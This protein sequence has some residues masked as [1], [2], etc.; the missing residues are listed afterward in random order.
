MPGPMLNEVLP[1]L[2]EEMVFLLKQQGADPLEAPLRALTIESVCDC[3]DENC[4]S[5]ATAP[6]VKVA[7]YVELATME[8]QLILDLNDRNEIC[9][10]EVLGRPDVKYLLEEFYDSARQ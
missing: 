4:A 1:D 2:L 3:G 9:F 10:V 5:F 6:E 8:G 7:N